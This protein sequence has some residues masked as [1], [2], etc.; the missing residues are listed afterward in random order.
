MSTKNSDLRRKTKLEQQ[1]PKEKLQAL[2]GNGQKS[3]FQLSKELNVDVG[4][5]K[6]LLIEYG[7]VSFSLPKKLYS[8]TKEILENDYTT[9]SLSKIAQKY[10]IGNTTISNLFN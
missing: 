9:L 5:L 8:L 10:S 7:I 3:I 1:F 4:R 6:I 2:W